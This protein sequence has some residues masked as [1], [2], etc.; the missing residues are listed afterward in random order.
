MSVWILHEHAEADC[1][2]GFVVTMY[3]YEPGVKYADG[4]D[5]FTVFRC[6]EHM[7]RKGADE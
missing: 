5:K 6:P 3:T 7:M 1:G 2:C 4:S